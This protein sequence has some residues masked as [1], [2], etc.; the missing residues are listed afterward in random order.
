MNYVNVN[1]IAGLLLFTVT[2]TI[3]CMINSQPLD[4]TNHENAQI[5]T[6]ESPQAIIAS[7][8][9]NNFVHNELLTLHATVQEIQ[10]ATDRKNLHGIF[11]KLTNTSNHAKKLQKNYWYF[12]H[13]HRDL[14]EYTVIHLAPTFY[15]IHELMKN[16]CTEINNFFVTRELEILYHSEKI[17]WLQPLI[18]LSHVLY[19]DLADGHQKQLISESELTVCTVYQKALNRALEQS[20]MCV[21]DYV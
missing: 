9:F 5:V 1:A 2:N 21:P 12:Y 6:Q 19:G 4:R 10:K 18:D 15:A 13:K 20:P 17:N 3:F 8:L 11:E 14:R 7:L 16:L